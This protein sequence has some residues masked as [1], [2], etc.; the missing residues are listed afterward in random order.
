M[1]CSVVEG[2]EDFICRFYSGLRCEIQGMVDYKEF[3]TI[4]Q[5]FQFNM[6]AEKELQGHE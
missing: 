6:L 3:H 2:N 4:N 1:R 5:L